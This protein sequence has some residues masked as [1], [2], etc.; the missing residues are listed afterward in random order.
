[1]VCKVVDYH[2]VFNFVFA[3]GV[4][5]EHDTVYFVGTVASVSCISD[6]PTITIKWFNDNQTVLASVGSSQR[7]LNL[8]F[9]PVSDTDQGRLYT[10]RVNNANNRELISLNFTLEIQGIAWHQS[11][12]H[13]IQIQSLILS[14]S[15][16]QCA[17]CKCNI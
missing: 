8:T 7:N 6:V 12:N 11:H 9:N 15:T 14:C 16:S 2:I 17:E 10:C 13:Y 5:I 4:I 3:L 1:M